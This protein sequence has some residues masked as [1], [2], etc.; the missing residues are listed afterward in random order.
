MCQCVQVFLKAAYKTKNKL[1][2]LLTEAS[3][4]TFF[5]RTIMEEQLILSWLNYSSILA[6]FIEYVSGIQSSAA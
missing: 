6:P 1:Y 3:K 2:N 4:I 5:K